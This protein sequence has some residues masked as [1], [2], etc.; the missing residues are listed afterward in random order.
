MALTIK[1]IEHA[2]EG[3]HADGGGLYLRVQAGGS[4]GWIFRFQLNKR[5]REM[6]IGSFPAK[7]LAEARAEAAELSRQVK[8]GIDPIQERKSLLLKVK[9]ATTPTIQALTF[10]E[11]ATAYIDGKASGWSNAKHAAQWRTTLSDYCLFKSK[12]VNDVT[13]DDIEEA[14][15]PIWLEKSETAT[16]LLA[17]I[18]SVLTFAHDKGWREVS[19]ANTYPKR[20]R[21]RLPSMGSKRQRTQHHPALPFNLVADFMRELR[22]VT[23][24]SARALELAIL[25]ANRASEV[26]L[27]QWSEFDLD[28][29]L[30]V[31]PAARMKAKREHRVPLSIQA[32]NML[33]NMPK[34]GTYVFAGTKANS[35]ISNMTMTAHIRR[36][37]EK[38]LIWV[39]HTGVPIV[40]HGFR[41]TFRDWA[42]ETTNYPTTVCEM[43]LAHVV[44]NQVEAAYRRGDLFDKRKELMQH[45]ADYCDRTQGHSEAASCQNP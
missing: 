35:P 44:A 33:R 45:W 9:E 7:R 3:M 5:R 23:S 13:V 22:Q 11:A 21:S 37:N 30:W 40:Q 34:L 18:V 25:C 14:L 1:Q 31:I 24:I 20:L 6:G 42:A 27:A 2:N 19:D 41:S 39:D 26:R 43:A 4:K 36:S 10:A 8:N 12:Y 16:R 17:R 29:A 28:A 32:I 38:E 15:R